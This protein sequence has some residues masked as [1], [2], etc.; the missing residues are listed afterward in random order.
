MS[1]NWKI[2]ICGAAALVIL[3]ILWRTGAVTSVLVALGLI[4]SAMY[5]RESRETDSR[6]EEMQT[7]IGHAR[8]LKKEHS[9]EVK[10]IE[11]DVAGADIDSLIRRANQRERDRP[12]P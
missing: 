6:V 4:G 9:E 5:T 2:A 1:R 12:K 7:T 10:R 8:I 11:K 3:L